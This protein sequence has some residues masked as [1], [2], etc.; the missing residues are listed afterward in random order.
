M[1]GRVLWYV[2]DHG[3]GHL[4]RA[5]AVIPLLDAPVVVAAAPRV[6]ADADRFLEG[7]V[8]ALPADVGNETALT[9]G[10]W[11]H[12]PAGA[13]VRARSLAM[14]DAVRAH[15]CTTAVV[16][17][18]ME[19][20]VLCRLLGLRVI[21]LRQSGR[22]NDAPHRTGLASADRV[23]VPQHRDLERHVD[24]ADGRWTFTGPFSRFDGARVP[25]ADIDCWRP[26]VGIRRA[27]I[28][29]GAGGTAF[30]TRSWHAGTVP[31]GWDVVIVGHRRRW[32]GERVT[33]IGQ[34]ES[35]LPLL[36]AAD[37]V[38]TAA[39]WGSIADSVAAGVEHLVVV[40]E[41][42]PFDEQQVRATALEAAALAVRSERWPLP[43]ELDSIEQQAARLDRASWSRFHDGHGAQRAADLIDEVHAA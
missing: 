38:I 16:D 18:S 25:D 39:G 41:D 33:S 19:A 3:R 34:L 12:A 6:A 11:H 23:W 24:D 29:V 5:R 35:L 10:P 30:P 1:T 13:A 8:I 20:T 27:V 2:H 22:R 31:H 17:V 28:V 36:R 43:S 15:D 7:A 40:P 32:A 21:T 4:D 9:V 37:L 42:R 14:A 26:G